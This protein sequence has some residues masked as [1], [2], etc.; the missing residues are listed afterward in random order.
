MKK[1]T[2]LRQLFILKNTINPKNPFCRHH[3]GQLRVAP[4]HIVPGRNSMSKKIFYKGL[5]KKI[6]FRH[7]VNDDD[8]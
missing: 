6:N 2:M 8:S 5:D 7:T 1:Y 3:V 4:E